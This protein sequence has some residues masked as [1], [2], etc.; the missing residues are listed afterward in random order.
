MEYIKCLNEHP[1]LQSLFADNSGESN[2]SLVVHLTP[3][4][5]AIE[6]EYLKWMSRSDQGSVVPGAQHDGELMRL[7]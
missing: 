2:V 5:I 4:D 1:D 6:V 7:L 3:P